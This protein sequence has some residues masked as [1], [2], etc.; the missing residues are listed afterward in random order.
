MRINNSTTTILLLSPLAL[1]LVPFSL[2][3]FVIGPCLVLEVFSVFKNNRTKSC[4]PLADTVD[5]LRD[6]FHPLTHFGHPF[7]RFFGLLKQNFPILTAVFVGENVHLADIG[8]VN[9]LRCAALILAQFN[10]GFDIREL[11]VSDVVNLVPVFQ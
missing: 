2:I 10:G 1:R 6:L 11:P 3:I 8:V 9:F 4:N 5:P 7:T